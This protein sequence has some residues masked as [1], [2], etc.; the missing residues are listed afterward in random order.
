LVKSD[1]PSSR[2]SLNPSHGL[3]LNYTRQ[4]QGPSPTEILC[5]TFY[6]FVVDRGGLRL[7]FIQFSSI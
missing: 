7:S 4:V 6:T 5:L 3:P 2:I 1:I